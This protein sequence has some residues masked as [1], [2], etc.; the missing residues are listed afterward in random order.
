MAMLGDPGHRWIT[1]QGGYDGNEAVLD[2]WVTEGGVFDS[3]TPRPERYRDGEILLEFMTCNSGTVS[4]DIPSIDR[5][6]VVPIQRITLDNV[7]L[8]SSMGIQA[9]DEAN[10]TSR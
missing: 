5:Q 1:A 8:C 10:D 7:G 4:Y 3:E 6:G 9:E 2:V